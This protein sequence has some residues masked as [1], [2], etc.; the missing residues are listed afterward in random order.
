MNRGGIRA[1]RLG[2]A[3]SGASG[4]VLAAQAY[5]VWWTA[6]SQLSSIA[7]AVAFVVLA[8]REPRSPWLRGALATDMLLV[9]LAYLPMQNGNLFHAWSLLEHVVTPLLVLTD[10]LLVGTNQADV[11]WW[12]PLTWLL[13]PAAYLSWYVCGD[14]CVYSALDLTRPT[15]FT[16]RCLV[17]CAL[18]LAVGTALYS[19]GRRRRTPVVSEA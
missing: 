15:Q 10:F 7:V 8:F 17:L 12:H 9:S 4:A 1:W 3:A 14:L 18:V 11:R 2:V 13:P 16:E 19:S 6:L 5:D